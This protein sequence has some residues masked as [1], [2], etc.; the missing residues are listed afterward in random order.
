MRVAGFYE[1]S[2]SNG[3]GWRAVLFVSGCP[4]RCKGCHNMEAWNSNYGIEYVESYYLDK[5]KSSDILSGLTLSGGEPF[6]YAKELIPLVK[7][8]KEL[9]L[10][11]WSYTG[12]TLE[13]LLEQNDPYKLELLEEIDV[14]VDGKYI[15][16]LKDPEL[17]FRGSTNQ[18]IINLNKLRA[19]NKVEDCLID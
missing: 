5:I 13:E 11:V 3:I 9:G 2:I 17:R 16:E 19:G 10:N 4:H 6:L 7:K 1:E 14:L 18:R 8:V 12:Y 15:E